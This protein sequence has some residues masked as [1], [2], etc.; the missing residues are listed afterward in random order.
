MSELEASL[1]Q[2]TNESYS[3]RAEI[4]KYMRMLD[5]KDG[6]IARLQREL[7]AAAGG[8]ALQAEVESLR[9]Q[10][11]EKDLELARAR[12]ETTQSRTQIDAVR[13]QSQR[14][15]ELAQQDAQQLRA[16]A[17]A[18]HKL[19]V[20]TGEELAKTRG[21]VA[22]L[23]AAARLHAGELEQAQQSTA[24]LRLQLQ[25]QGTSEEAYQRMWHDLHELRQ[26]LAKKDA[27]ISAL[28]ACQALPPPAQLVTPAAVP[29]PQNQ[30]G[31]YI[32]V[33]H[34]NSPEQ[35]THAAHIPEQPASNPYVPPPAQ[36]TPA[37]S[38]Q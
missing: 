32:A 1:T 28:K 23:Q 15:I 10:L 25:H 31:Y 34:T 21:Q 20:D 14:H 17:E 4:S 16:N 11:A 8:P 27:E 13:S 24:A 30:T 6:E 22:D 36:P 35:P 33:G 3:V 9:K 5:E 7:A 18:N 26:L 19:A 38:Y 37:P 2:K 29:P 12:D